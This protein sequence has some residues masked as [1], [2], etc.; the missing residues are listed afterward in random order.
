MGTAASRGL[1]LAMRTGP[2]TRH[3]TLSS[4]VLA[5]SVSNNTEFHPQGSHNTTAAP[6]GLTLAMRTGQPTVRATLSSESSGSST[7]IMYCALG[8]LCQAQS[9]VQV[10]TRQLLRGQSK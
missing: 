7:L 4:E 3:A 9:P 6:R 8:H 10:R 1:Q 5:A 2:P